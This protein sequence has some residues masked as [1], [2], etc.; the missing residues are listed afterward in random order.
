MYGK[1]NAPSVKV[2]KIPPRRQ[3]ASRIL[4][5]A[6]MGYGPRRIVGRDC[7]VR[8]PPTILQTRHGRISGYESVSSISLDYTPGSQIKRFRKCGRKWRVSPPA[9]RFPVVAVEAPDS[10]RGVNDFSPR[11]GELKRGGRHVPMP[12]Y[13]S[14]AWGYLSLHCSATRERALRPSSFTPERQDCRRRWSSQQ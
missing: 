14:M 5:R 1:T 3:T 8:L 4:R 9:L 13:R 12:T 2:Y 6:P 7:R 10:V 11:R